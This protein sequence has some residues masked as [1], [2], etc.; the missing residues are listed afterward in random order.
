MHAVLMKRFLPL[1]LVMLVAACSQPVSVT[2]DDDGGSVAL[3]VA[4]ELEVVLPG[5]PTTGYNWY[6]TSIDPAVLATAGEPTF[7]PDSTLVGAAGLV[8]LSSTAVGEGSTTLELAYARSFE[9]SPPDDTYFLE[10][11]VS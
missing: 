5:N 9:N 4:E 8:H 3:T 2:A 7:E 10:V 1:G 11:E 6:V